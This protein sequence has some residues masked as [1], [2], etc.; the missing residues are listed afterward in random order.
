MRQTKFV[1]K[2]NELRECLKAHKKT[3]NEWNKSEYRYK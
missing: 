3:V 1:L 2:I